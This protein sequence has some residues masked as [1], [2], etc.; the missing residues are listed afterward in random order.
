VAK[1]RRVK[2][3][4]DSVQCFYCEAELRGDELRCPACGKLFREGKM[5][6]A[7]AVAAAVAVVILVYA[8]WFAPP[9]STGSGTG[10]QAFHAVSLTVPSDTHAA[11]AGR[12][13]GFVLHITNFGNVVDTIGI[14]TELPSA[15]WAALADEPSLTL[16]PG[17]TGVSVLEII[18]PG[19]APPGSYSV[20]VTA[21]SGGDP[22]KWYSHT[23]TVNV[24][25]LGQQ[26]V[27]VGDKVQVD[28]T[29]WLTN[30][31]EAD[32]SISRGEP[33]KVYVGSQDPD[34]SDDYTQVIQ[35]FWEA[36]RGM[37]VGETTAVR[38]PPEK[39]YSGSHPLAGMTLIFEI[40]LVSID[41]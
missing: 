19:E 32:S 27:Q 22:T 16:T 39:A 5:W 30:G 15:Q 37:K 9:A 35:G 17:T 2:S 13:T 38:V 34:P 7:A 4:R 11:E 6:S 14:S 40:E 20:T 26:T 1:R 28:Y 31:S 21:R 33:L 12:T 25:G 23:L 18:L 8:T 3:A 24:V 10:P 36:I 29:L 41:G